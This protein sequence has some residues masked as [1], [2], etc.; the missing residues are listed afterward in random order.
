VVE[1]SH[2][3]PSAD[4]HEHRGMPNTETAHHLYLYFHLSSNRVPGVGRN[5]DILT[6]GSEVTGYKR[7]MGILTG[8]REHGK[9]FDQGIKCFCEIFLA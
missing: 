4:T 8:A 6:S 9:C 1:N 5:Q 3:V 2:F 7:R